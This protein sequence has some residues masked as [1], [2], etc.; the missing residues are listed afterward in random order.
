LNSVWILFFW[1]FGDVL[2][3]I[4]STS[5]EWKSL[6]FGLQIA[7]LE[8]ANLH[9]LHQS[10]NPISTSQKNTIQAEFNQRCQNERIQGDLIFDTGKLDEILIERAFWADLLIIT[11]NQ[12]GDAGMFSLIRACPVPL[13]IINNEL[14]QFKK[15]LL[16]YN[17]RPKAEEALFLSAFMATF[18]E[19][20]LTVL[21]CR[22][23]RFV[24]Q[25]T[26]LNAKE[27]LKQYRVTANYLE[28]DG[29][30]GIEILKT[31]QEDHSDIIILGGYD[32]H[33]R[34]GDRGIQVLNRV[35][36]EFQNGVMICR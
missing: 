5:S 36:T 21:T 15:I 1:L 25:D 23:D 34:T 17:G 20:S 18:W 30:P 3:A 12:I 16:A 22:D 35:I 7:K 33:T 24:T 6:D 19:L 27:Y 4:D 29:D 2:V 11:A 9:G 26:I 31:A 14:S 28:I 10:S 13:F 32:P 8:G